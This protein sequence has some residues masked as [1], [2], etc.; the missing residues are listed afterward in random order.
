MEGCNTVLGRYS[1]MHL[2]ES[3]DSASVQLTVI[4]RLCFR[5][6]PSFAFRATDGIETQKVLQTASAQ[7]VMAPVGEHLTEKRKGNWTEKQNL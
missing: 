6:L 5:V 1:A 7:N 2:C 3:G 4:C